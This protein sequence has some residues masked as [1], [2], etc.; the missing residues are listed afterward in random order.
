VDGRTF[1]VEGCDPQGTPLRENLTG[2]LWRDVFVDVFAVD[3]VLARPG[4]E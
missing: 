2:A 1:E 4:G 3:Y